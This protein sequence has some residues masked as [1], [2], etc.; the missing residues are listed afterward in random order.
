MIERV[1]DCLDL[2][3][4]AES[5]QCFRWQKTGKNSYEVIAFDRYLRITG[6]GNHFSFSCDNEEFEKIWEEYLDLKTDYKALKEM[7]ADTEDEF[8]KKAMDYGA[9]I[10][11][12]KQDLWEMILSFI[13]SQNNN[14]PRIKKII[15]KL[16]EQFGKPVY[17]KGALVGYSFPAPEAFLG[18]NTEDLKGLGLGYRDKYVLSAADWYVSERERDV[19]KLFA[20]ESTDEQRKILM[21]GICGVGKKVA[22]CILL[23]GLQKKDCCPVDTW[24]KKLFDEDYGGNTPSWVNSDYAGVFQQY[25]FY[26][27][28]NEGSRLIRGE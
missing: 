4:I 5:G 12:L 20:C 24:M 18:L 16:C 25:A 2:D 27:K 23:F 6:N 13:I 1:I 10:R 22:N 9:G 7:M 8:I 19:K 28:K 11:I 26:Y 3:Q 14:I 17:F 21:D 15:E